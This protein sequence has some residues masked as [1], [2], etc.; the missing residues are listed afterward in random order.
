MSL[1]TAVRKQQYLLLRGANPQRHHME[2]SDQ[3]GPEVWGAP[4]GLSGGWL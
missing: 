2:H 3:T 4:G 1:D